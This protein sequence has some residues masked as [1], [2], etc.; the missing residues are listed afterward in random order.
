M[1]EHKFRRR[2]GKHYRKSCHK[3]NE[4]INNVTDLYSHTKS[5]MFTE[6]VHGSAL[7]PHRR[8]YTQ[9][10]IYKINKLI[11]TIS[12]CLVYKFLQLESRIDKRI[13]LDFS[14]VIRF[15]WRTVLLTPTKKKK[16]PHHTHHPLLHQTSMNRC[17]ILLV[18]LVVGNTIFQLV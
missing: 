16:H 18:W 9:S 17:A 10:K 6:N 13:E 12:A 2:G 15:V 4:K 3:V 11:D 7:S 8:V 5:K 1:P 14:S